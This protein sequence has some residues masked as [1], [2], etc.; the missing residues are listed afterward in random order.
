VF[1]VEYDRDAFDGACRAAAIPKLA[2]IFKN[3]TLDPCRLA[4]GRSA[5]ECPGGAAGAPATGG[6]GN[7]NAATGTGSSG[8]G[9]RAG[10]MLAPLLLALAGVLALLG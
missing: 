6:G 1:V 5:P 9:L 7:G 4:C 8:A 2:T 3:L 10:G